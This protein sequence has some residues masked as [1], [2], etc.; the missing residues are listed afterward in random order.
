MKVGTGFGNF[1]I[2]LLF[3][4]LQKCA[5]PDQPRHIKG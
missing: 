2:V 5:N 4:L 3:M 1:F